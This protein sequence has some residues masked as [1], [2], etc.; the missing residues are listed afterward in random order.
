MF[1]AWR[2]R[3]ID[4][5]LDWHVTASFVDRQAYR[6]GGHWNLLADRVFKSWHQD[7]SVCAQRCTERRKDANGR[8]ASAARRKVG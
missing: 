3:L 8:R 6:P 7:L 4:L 1:R 2:W 5:D